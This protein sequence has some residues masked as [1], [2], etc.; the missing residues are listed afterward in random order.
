[1]SLAIRSACRR[2]TFG[3]TSTTKHTQ[4]S[5]HNSP[6][7]IIQTWGL[8]TLEDNGDSVKLPSSSCT[9]HI[10]I[11]TSNTTK[12]TK[13]P[14]TQ[15]ESPKRGI[16][17]NRTTLQQPTAEPKPTPSNVHERRT[18]V[19]SYYNQPAIDNAAAKQS[20]RLTPATIM[21][22]GRSFDGS[23]VMVRLKTH[24]IK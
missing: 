4:V 22:A 17:Y 18:T 11:K 15:A 6:S 8:H 21:Y 20:V 5:R 13:V 19:A 10:K 14:Y 7:N 12:Y 3:G 9:S 1:M 2:A 23:H 24:V 16:H